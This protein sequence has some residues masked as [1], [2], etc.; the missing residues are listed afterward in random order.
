MNAAKRTLPLFG[1]ET[2]DAP[3]DRERL[4]TLL[5]RVK[6]R[7]LSGH[8]YTIAELA[9]AAGGRSEASISARIR[10]LRKEKFGGYRVEARRREPLK[11]GLFEYRLRKP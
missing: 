8:W 5:E 10:D 7:M 11:L 2:Y 6:A 3:L 9:A 4:K 1:G